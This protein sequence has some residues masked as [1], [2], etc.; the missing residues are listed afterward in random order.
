MVTTHRVVTLR[1]LHDRHVVLSDLHGVLGD[2]F[3]DPGLVLTGEDQRPRESTARTGIG[4][5]D[6]H[7]GRDLLWRELGLVGES[8]FTRTPSW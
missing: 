7:G 8:A 1:A 2:E 4:R 3:R 5:V 6:F